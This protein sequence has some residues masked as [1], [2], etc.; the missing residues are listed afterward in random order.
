MYDNN[1]PDLPLEIIIKGCQDE[2]KHDRKNEK[3]YCFELFRRALDGKDE[4]A[5]GAIDSQYHRLVLSWI[6]A[7]NPKLSQ[8]EIEDL[9][10]D[11]LQKFF[12]T[13]TRH[14]DLIVE[15]FKHVGALLKYLNR[16]AITTMLDYQ[17]YIQR[18]ARLQERLQVVYDKEVLGLTTEQKVLD[19]IYWEA[20]LDK[21][22]E[23]LW[24]NVTNPLEQKILQYSFE[25]GLT[26][27]EIT[28]FY[29]DDFPDVQ[30][31]R[32][33]KERVLKRIRRALK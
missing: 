12:N 26:P 14:D 31:V 4:N 8:D 21:F 32:R 1:L 6:Q 3:G 11:T 25:E 10:Q 29:P 22:K 20:E 16:C 5:W 15:R 9:G 27:I 7:K 19:Q 2:S 17:R 13:L 24:K 28:E 18:V 23:W 33:V 30:T